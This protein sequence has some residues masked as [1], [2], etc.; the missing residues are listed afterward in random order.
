MPDAS[1]VMEARVLRAAYH[2][3][4]CDVVALDFFAQGRHL[5]IDA[6]VTTTYKNTVLQKIASIPGNEAKQAEDRK[7]LAD[8]TPSQPIA[9]PYGGLHV[10]VPFAIESWR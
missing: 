8:R 4:S 5:A 1:V 2:S 9:T 6:I 7:F 3:G 10:L